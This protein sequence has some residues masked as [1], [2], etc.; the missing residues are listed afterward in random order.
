MA[1]Q[2]LFCRIIRGDLPSRKIFEDDLFLA[3]EDIHPQAPVH[4][5][6]IPKKHIENIS[7]LKD[8]D[9]ALAGEMMIRIRHLAAQKGWQD[10]RLVTNN[11][12]QAQQTVYHLHFHLLS[13]RSMTWPPG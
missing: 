6:F 13:G 4:I 1:E 5:L 9:A 7:D 3:F 2:C 10:F 8:Q 12:V 11:G